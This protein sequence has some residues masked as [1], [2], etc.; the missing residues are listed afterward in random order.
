VPYEKISSRGTGSFFQGGR[1][2]VESSEVFISGRHSTEVG[3]E[4]GKVNLETVRIKVTDPFA[5]V[6]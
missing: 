2:K 6:G 5:D 1:K 3:S 4:K